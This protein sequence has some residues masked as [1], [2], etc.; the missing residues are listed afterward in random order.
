M[1]PRAGRIR[2]PDQRLRVF[3]SSTL[4]ELGAERRAARSAIE[5]L[6]MAPV[7]FELGAR[8]HPPRDL[9]RAYLEQSDVFVGLYWERY[10]WV[11]PDEAVSGL[12]DEYNLAP[13]SMPKLIYIKDSPAREQRLKDLLDR[14]RSDDMASYKSFA[15]SDELGEYLRGDLATLLAE[16]FDQSR[17]GAIRDEP[18]QQNARTTH[19]PAPLTELIGRDRDVAEVVD[20]LS[21]DGVR[22][23]TIVGPGG[24]GKSRVAI[25]AAERLASRFD[26]A[27]V[28]VDLASA[29]QPSLVIG[30]MAQA[31]GVYDLG[32]LPLADKVATALSG[33]RSLLVLDNFEQ[34][35]DAAPLLATLLSA[36]PDLSFIVTSRSRLRLSGEQSYELDPLP[37]PVIDDDQDEPLDLP[38]LLSVPSVALFVAR[39]RAVKPDFEVT[40]DNAAAVAGIC[41]VLDGVPLALE[42]AAARIRVLTPS[43]MLKRLDRQLPLLVEGVRDLPERQRTLRSTIEWSTR[44][45]DDEEN[46]LLA[47]L[48]VFAGDFSLDAAEAVWAETGGTASDALTLLGALVDNSLVRQRDRGDT[49]MF[50]LLT[51][52][53]EYAVERLEAEGSLEEIRGAHAAYYLLLTEEMRSTLTGRLQGESVQ[54]LSRENDNLRAAIRF[55]IESDELDKAA[56]FAWNLYI[57]SWVD[58]HLGEVRAWM[59]ELLARNAPI[60]DLTRA[61][62]LYFT[63]AITFWQD[64]DGIVIPGLAESADLF[65]RSGDL[66]GSALA[67]ISLALALLSAADADPPRA[68]DAL[69][70]SLNLF[71]ESHDRWGQAMALVTLGRVAL[72]NRKEHAALNRFEESLALAESESDELGTTIALH[73]LGWAHLLLGAVEHAQHC[74]ER[75]LFLSARLGHDEGVAY[76]LEGLVAIAAARGDIERAGRLAGAAHSLRERAGLYNAPTFSFHEAYLAPVRS[77]AAA[78]A[79]ASAIAAGERMSPEEATTLALMPVAVEAGSATPDADMPGSPA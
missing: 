69:E 53:R 65:R 62:A 18:Q 52:V 55:L 56:R 75:S 58:G 44:L 37:V 31:L 45:L 48:G 17:A 74:F 4:T 8:P 68:D 33:R 43:A 76:G 49:S 3:V 13:A 30:A 34:V 71:R 27:V 63:R 60:S 22:L 26:D 20:L 47:R 64:P 2:T 67:L 15:T 24:I 21:T 73:H 23:V 50:S 77:S 66:P 11:A 57:Y 72:L 59:T 61:I 6:R 10:G 40:E 9:Y 25:E 51:I 54:R 46:R 38:S 42:L 12:E 1:N 5:D 39:V 78:D 32:D 14:V 29:T 16:R 35:L 79:L 70:T 41:A 36:V 19:L 7:M 28:F